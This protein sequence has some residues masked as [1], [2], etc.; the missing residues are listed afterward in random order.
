MNLKMV[1]YGNTVE[2]FDKE[3]NVWKFECQHDE[4]ECWG[5]LYQTCLIHIYPNVEQHFRV[6]ECIE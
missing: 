2:T 4:D 1:P 6:I 3:N 5:N